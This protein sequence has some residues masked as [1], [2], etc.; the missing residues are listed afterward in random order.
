MYAL[1]AG[2]ATVAI[3]LDDLER[4]ERAVK[5]G[6]LE[7]ACKNLRETAEALDRTSDV[8]EKHWSEIPEPIRKLLRLS[9][10]NAMEERLS[11][12]T[13]LRH[14]PAF[15]IA[16][17]LATRLVIGGGDPSVTCF[18]KARQRY[19]STILDA[20][21]RENESFQGDLSRALAKLPAS[22]ENGLTARQYMERLRELSDTAV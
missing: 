8:I 20:I 19:I 5:P 12:G 10:Y 17:S 1:N 16:A 9:A 6:L 14:F 11:F 22:I 7:L 13:I 2:G 4:C 3:R 18:I 21:E 15:V